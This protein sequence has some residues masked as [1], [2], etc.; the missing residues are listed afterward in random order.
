MTRLR[1]KIR[2]LKVDG[3]NHSLQSH[4]TGQLSGDSSAGFGEASSSGAKP[5]NT[6]LIRKKVRHASLLQFSIFTVTLGPHTLLF[7][8]NVFVWTVRSYYRCRTDPTR[9]LA[10]RKRQPTRSSLR[11]RC[12]YPMNCQSSIAMPK[13]M[14]EISV[15]ITPQ[16][17]SVCASLIWK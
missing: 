9:R 1:E 3:W 4:L 2:T 7:P 14:I 15:E 6:S 13:P 11:G 5:I 12:R 16:V 17:F 10:T 8:F